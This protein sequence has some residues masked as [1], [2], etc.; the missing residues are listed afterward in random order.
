MSPRIALRRCPI[1]A[2]LLGLMLVCSTSECR[3]SRRRLELAARGN[4]RTRRAAIQPR[5]DV[6][7]T[8][9]LE[10]G[11][12]VNRAQRRHHLLGNLARS[13]AQLARQLKGQ[14]QRILAE[15]HLRRLSRSR[16]WQSSIWYFARAA[17]RGA[18][19]QAC[20]AV[21]RYT[22]LTPESALKKSLIFLADSSRA[23]SPAHS[24]TRNPSHT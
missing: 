16:C 12:A 21:L 13:L 2:A 23:L 3:C 19:L 7:R 8:G 20:S 9:D 17:P 1:C 22:S 18:A 6:A 5:I 10:A 11:E 4:R 24:S 14:R 15:L